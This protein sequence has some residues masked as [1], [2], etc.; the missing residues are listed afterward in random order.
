VIAHGRELLDEPD[1]W[2]AIE[3]S[4]EQCAMTQE[5]DR[6]YAGVLASMAGSAAASDGTCAPGATPPVAGPHEHQL[7]ELMANTE[8]LLAA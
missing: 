2:R 7:A 8:Q 4:F 1:P 3:R 6:A 5:Q